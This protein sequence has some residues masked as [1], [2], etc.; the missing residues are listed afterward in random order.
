MWISTSTGFS[1]S[2]GPSVPGN[3]NL[4]SLY[5]SISM[6]NFFKYFPVTV[7]YVIN[8]T[9]QIS[10]CT[11]ISL[12][13]Q[14]YKKIFLSQAYS[15]FLAFYVQFG[16]LLTNFWFLKQQFRPILI[17]LPEEAEVTCES[18]FFYWCIFKWQ[19]SGSRQIVNTQALWMFLAQVSVAAVGI[20]SQYF[21]CLSIYEFGFFS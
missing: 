13:S 18:S 5:S 11:D 2:F 7:L 3:V 16:L 17:P 15:C 9:M 12:S 20:S 21:L 1:L 10:D 8:T 14:V 6:C 4:V 19:S